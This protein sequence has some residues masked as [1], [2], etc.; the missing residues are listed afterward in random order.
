MRPTPLRIYWHG[1]QGGHLGIHRIWKKGK[2][3]G[4]LSFFSHPF[5]L[6]KKPFR[7]RSQFSRIGCFSIQSEQQWTFT[8]NRPKCRSTTVLCN[9]FTCVKPVRRVAWF[10]PRM[11]PTSAVKS[12]SFERL[13]MVIL[14]QITTALSAPC[15]IPW[16]EPSKNLPLQEVQWHWPCPSSWPRQPRDPPI[17]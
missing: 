16:P 15:S 5:L 9:S 14:H 1:V 17:Q 10:I 6:F 2:Q 8:A 4:L 11:S 13:Q 3:L 12:G 7:V